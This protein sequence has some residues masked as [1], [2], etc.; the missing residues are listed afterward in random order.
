MMSLGA[1]C[2]TPR[3]DH[4][5]ARRDANLRSNR[6]IEDHERQ[7]KSVHVYIDTA[8]MT[9]PTLM[10]TLYVQSGGSQEIFSFEYDPG[11]LESEQAFVFDPD[12]QLLGGPQ[13]PAQSRECW[14]IA[15]AKRPGFDCQKRG[16]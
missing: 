15:W 14:H 13:Y 11:W 6:P 9:G 1:N 2:K 10:G 5:R 12:L 3:L 8:G 7:T 4:G 16:C